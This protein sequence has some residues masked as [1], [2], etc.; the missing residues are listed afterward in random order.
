MRGKLGYAAPEQVVG[1]MYD[2]R[3]DLFALGLTLHECLTGNRTFRAENDVEL[4]RL[5][6]EGPIAG[7]RV[8]RA[9][10]PEELDAVVMTLLERDLAKRTPSA[11]ELRRKLIELPRELLDQQQGRKLLAAL[12]QK[13][14]TWLTSQPVEP[15]AKITS[16]TNRTDETQASLKQGLS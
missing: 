11:Y 5:V 12:V 16:T 2:G 13:T 14:R 3:A 8:L 7:P 9:D 1:S 4:M 15:D 10:V 6:M